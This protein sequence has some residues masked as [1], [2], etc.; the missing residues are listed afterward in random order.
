MSRRRGGYNRRY[1]RGLIVFVIIVILAIG[2]GYLTTKYFIG[3]FFGDKMNADTQNSNDQDFSGSSII[4]GQQDITEENNENIKTENPS[5]NNN[6]D[7]KDENTQYKITLYCI[8]YGSFSSK[9]GAEQIAQNLKASNIDTMVFI[10]DG[11]YKVLGTPY[12]KEEVAREALANMKTIAGEDI[13][14]TTVEATMK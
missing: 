11:S 1:G 7:G 3:S 5:A 8:Q 9:E 13:F 14:I 2:S 4:V 6:A 10:T 12:I